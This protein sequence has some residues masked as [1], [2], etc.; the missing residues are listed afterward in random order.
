MPQRRTLRLSD[1]ER[2]VLVALRD[3]APVPYL[4]ERSSALLQIADG[5]APAVVAREGLLRGRD[6]DT[7]YS[8]LNRWLAEGVDSLPIRNGRGRRPAF[9][10]SALDARGGGGGD[11][12][13]GAA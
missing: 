1:E 7:V 3:K 13:S 12:A 5:T 11:T 6:A 9:S 8:W 4:R 10:P 2:E